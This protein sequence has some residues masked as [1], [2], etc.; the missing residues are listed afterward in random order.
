MTQSWGEGRGT[1]FFVHSQQVS[2]RIA[3]WAMKNSTTEWEVEVPVLNN[4][5][6]MA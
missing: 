1:Y 2:F 3:F 4:R 5:V 6:N